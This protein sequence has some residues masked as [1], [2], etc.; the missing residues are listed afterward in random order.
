M[1]GTR[2]GSRDTLLILFSQTQ[3][4][5]CQPDESGESARFW[6]CLIFFPLFSSGWLMTHEDGQASAGSARRYDLSLG[7]TCAI[8][9]H[10][11]SNSWLNPFLYLRPFL[12]FS[13]SSDCLTRLPLTVFFSSILEKKKVFMCDINSYESQRTMMDSSERNT[14]S[15]FCVQDSMLEKL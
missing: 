8:S 2:S 5:D 9:L 4:Q 11:Y 6:L 3:G 7:I 12:L 15:N 14:R 13:S 1:I 10:D